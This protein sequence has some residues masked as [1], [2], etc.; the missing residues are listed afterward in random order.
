MFKNKSIATIYIYGMAIM[1]CITLLFILLLIYEE[2]NEFERDSVRLRA[3]N[4]KTQKIK[5][6]DDTKRIISFLAQEKKR[7]KSMSQEEQSNFFNNIYFSSENRRFFFV[8]DLQKNIFIIPPAQGVQNIRL[9]IKKSEENNLQLYEDELV[10]MESVDDL[11]WI[12]GFSVDTEAISTEIIFQKEKLKKRLIKLMMEILSLGVILF[13]FM[14]ILAWVLHAIMKKQV[15][16]FRDYFQIASKSYSVIDQS[17]IDL[18]EFKEMVYYINNMVEEIHKRKAKLKEINQ[19]LEKKVEEK[20]RDIS[21]QNRLL[22]REKSFS[23]SLVKAQ[24]SFIRHSIHEI[25]TPLAVILNHIDIYKMKKGDDPYMMKIE[26]ATKMIANIY[27]DL[28][29]MVKKDRLEYKKEWLNMSR[30][31]K[32][33]IEFF[34][35]IATGNLHDIQSDL[36]NGVRLYFNPIELQRIIDNNLSNSI[37]YS[38][39]GST[40]RLSLHQEGEKV[41][42]RFVTASKKKIEDIHKIF[43]PFHREHSED[44]G[45]GIG[46][47]IVK[48]ICDKEKIMIDVSSDE[49]ET[50]FSYVFSAKELI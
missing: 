46:L 49:Y 8:Y 33:R 3:S 42:L 5:I 7:I 29:Y 48:T 50:I 23:E 2:Y 19:R 41:I 31:I 40:V 12:V 47:E 25:N 15:D 30:F 14:L 39:K 28:G 32:E 26:A 38:K 24:D 27:D 43:N 6:A 35:E 20:T 37:K 1:L 44:I 11:K 36:E 18:I 10:Y 34:K 9:G 17:R 22:E 21:L 4:I 16:I 13:G 45:F